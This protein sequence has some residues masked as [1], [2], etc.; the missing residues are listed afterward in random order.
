MKLQDFFALGDSGVITPDDAATLNRDLAGK[1]LSNI[2][3]E[4]RQNVLDYLLKA[5]QFDS[6]DHDIQVK[7]NALIAA[8]QANAVDPQL[9]GVE[10][11]KN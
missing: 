10:S 7:I 8:L 3:S 9:H 2:P 6:V 11:D 1:S 5:M 4:H